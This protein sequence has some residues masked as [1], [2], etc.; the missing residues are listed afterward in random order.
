MHWPNTNANK[1]WLEKRI[2]KRL[3]LLGKKTPH[4]CVL[5]GFFSWLKSWKLQKYDLQCSG[6]MPTNVQTAFNFQSGCGDTQVRQ[7]LGLTNQKAVTSLTDQSEARRV[8]SS[9]IR[10]WY[11]WQIYCNC[12]FW[13]VPPHDGDPP[14]IYHK[15]I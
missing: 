11:H 6:F 13:L 5:L 8:P 14:R 7:T 2:N 4:H 10:R 15:T 1:I 9:M 12:V 3:G